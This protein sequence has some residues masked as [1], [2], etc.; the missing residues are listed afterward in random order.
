MGALP[1]PAVENLD[2]FGMPSGPF[3]DCLHNR[4]KCIRAVDNSYVPDFVDRDVCP[5]NQQGDD[6]ESLLIVHRRI[7]QDKSK[8]IGKL[9]RVKTKSP[10]QYVTCDR[11]L[12]VVFNFI[13]FLATA[14]Q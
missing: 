7:G 11:A 10:C 6:G 12:A 3:P 14:A 1:P 8:Q 9:V 5:V 2:R 13:A 4:L